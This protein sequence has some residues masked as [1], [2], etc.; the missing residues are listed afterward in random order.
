MHGVNDRVVPLEWGEA[1]AEALPVCGRRTI[2][3]RSHGLLFR[4]PEARLAVIEFM[5]GVDASF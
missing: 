1:L 2:E 4:A 3:G 5:R